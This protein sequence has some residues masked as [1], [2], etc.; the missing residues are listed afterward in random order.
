MSVEADT[1]I[2]SQDAAEI[3]DNLFGLLVAGG[4]LAQAKGI[5]DEECEAMY[6]YGHSLYAQAKYNDAF[7]IFAQLVAY[8]HME[9]RYQ[10]ALASAMQ[11][12]KRYEE[13][14]RHYMI[15][16]VMRID[17]PVPVYH[18]AEC[19]L[20]LGRLS[21]AIETLGLVDTLCDADKHDSLK[22]RAAAL[23]KALKEKAAKAE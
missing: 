6:A 1:E 2:T 16:T 20:A 14:L 23:L 12:T 7:K 19:L 22:A 3:A 4:T 17:D 10:M 9:S 5:T 11:M 15:V 8:N 13:A 18:S 21:D